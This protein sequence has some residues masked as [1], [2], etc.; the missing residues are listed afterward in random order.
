WLAKYTRWRV[1]GW[2]SIQRVLAPLSKRA[3]AANKGP[4]MDT[5]QMRG[6]AGAN[7]G[8][9]ARHPSAVENELAGGTRIIPTTVA[10][11]KTRRFGT[12]AP[13]HCAENHSQRPFW[14]LRLRETRA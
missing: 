12:S 13:S 2:Q 10:R 1:S 8:T 7:R 6:R 3:R 14:R 5:S 4:V 11:A 9:K